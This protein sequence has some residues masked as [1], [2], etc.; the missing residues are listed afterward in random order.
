MKPRFSLWAPGGDQRVNFS[1]TLEPFFQMIFTTL[2]LPADAQHSCVLCDG[3][4]MAWRGPST[5]RDPLL[6][7]PLYRRNRAILKAM[8]LPCAVCGRT[9]MYSKPGQ[10]VAGHI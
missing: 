7:A 3:W 8:R 5:P 1:F 2:R 4:C 9:D 10:F 6:D